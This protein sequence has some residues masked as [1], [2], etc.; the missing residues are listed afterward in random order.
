M[1]KLGLIVLVSFMLVSCAALGITA[2]KD[3]IINK[4]VKVMCA[5]PLETAQIIKGTKLEGNINLDGLC[6]S[7]VVK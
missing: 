1:K 3:E 6:G 7:E 4:A 5:D 2:K